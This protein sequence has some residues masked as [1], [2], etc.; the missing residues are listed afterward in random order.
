M[1]R[2]LLIS[3]IV[4]GAA[5]LG[6]A[7][8]QSAS[9]TTT[10]DYDALG[11]LVS[12]ERS[13]EAGAVYLFDALGNRER[14]IGGD[15]VAPQIV[16]AVYHYTEHA[17]YEGELGMW[18]YTAT[19]GVVITGEDLEGDDITFTELGPPIKCTTLESPVNGDP[20]KAYCMV[21]LDIGFG[22]PPSLPSIPQGWENT[23]EVEDD[24]A[25][26][27]QYDILAT[28]TNTFV[29]LP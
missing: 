28:A 18:I 16:S 6:A 5:P 11:R 27:D 17:S 24:N 8:A 26:A 29:V 21:N 15:N 12:S 23:F 19:N 25:N 2:V 10:Y 22:F 9:P 7:F 1:R 14:V 20:D 4:L 13:G 3:A